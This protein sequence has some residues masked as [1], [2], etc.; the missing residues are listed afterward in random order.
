MIQN[1]QGNKKTMSTND[2][3]IFGWKMWEH[4]I[5]DSRIT[6]GNEIVE[7]IHHHGLICKQNVK[8]TSTYLTTK[9]L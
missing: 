5:P 6:V 9:C 3:D 4:G 2:E 8:F 7:Y 1:K